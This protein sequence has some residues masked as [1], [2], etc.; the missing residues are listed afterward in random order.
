VGALEK[1]WLRL[2][3]LVRHIR[4]VSFVDFVLVSGSMATGEATEESDFDLLVGARAGRIFTVRFFAA[5]LFE[6]LGVRRRSADGKGKSRDKI[7]LNH[8][9]TPQ[10]YRLG[11]PH[12]EY[13]AYLYRHLMP[14][15]GK[16][17]AI[18]VFFD[19]NTWANEPIYRGPSS[20]RR[21]W[22]LISVVGEWLFGGRLGNWLE[23]RL[24]RYEVKRI[25]RNLASS[26]GYK[27][28]VR[29]D[30]AELRFHTDTRRIEEWCLRNTLTKQ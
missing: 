24:K 5:G 16:K 14:I 30:D 22:S 11:E 28:V 17:E 6:F 23:K 2:R 29:Y 7:C 10:S 19:A 18:E 4:H 25:E 20:I 1:K 8:F 9:V 15:Y 12:N 26:L 21:E 13:W 27:P 3:S